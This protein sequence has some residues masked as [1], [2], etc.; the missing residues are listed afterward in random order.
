[1]PAVISKLSKEYLYVPITVNVEPE[2][3]ISPVSM[4]LSKTADPGTFY[5]AEYVPEKRA[6]RMLVGPGTAKGELT[7]GRWFVYVKV[8]D[9]PEDPVKTAL[10]HVN[11]Y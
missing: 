1:M 4:A 6:I 2:L 3:F 8:D 5:T 11:V 7:P 9:A 10:S